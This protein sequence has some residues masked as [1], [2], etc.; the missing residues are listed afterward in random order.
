MFAHASISRDDVGKA[1]PQRGPADHPGAARRPEAALVGPQVA[2]S[3][4][5]V[6]HTGCRNGAQPP[7]RRAGGRRR[8]GGLGEGR[9]VGEMR[10]G[11]GGRRRGRA[12]R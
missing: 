10:V 11:E 12:R 1:K 5:A 2:A 7:R 9:R 8:G 4:A 3:A 6:W